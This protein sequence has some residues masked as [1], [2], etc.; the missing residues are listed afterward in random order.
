MKR[1]LLL[2]LAISALT[3]CNS[4]GSGFDLKV[5]NDRVS[6]M[7]GTV[8]FQT[9][10]DS[11][12][13]RQDYTGFQAYLKCDNGRIIQMPADPY[14]LGYGA[15][16]PMGASGM[17]VPNNGYSQ[18]EILTEDDDRMV[19][20]L[21]HDPWTLFDE[22]ITLDKQITLFRESPIMAVID[23][24]S[25]SFDLLNVAAGLTSAH[26]GTVKELERGYS[27]DYPNGI[28][29]IIIM[30][31]M[32]QKRFNEFQGRVFVS[33]GVTSDEPLHYYIGISDKGKDYLLEELAKIL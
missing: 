28:T 31:G 10:L 19:I 7:N 26:V 21:H 17:Y 2:L 20:R 14:S 29:A 33:K 11:K 9:D 22:P 23:Y 18:A 8:R 27:I 16:F 15:S 30:P 5:R 3:G 4:V 24:Y 25:G 32:E 6:W 1:I 13:K 12:G